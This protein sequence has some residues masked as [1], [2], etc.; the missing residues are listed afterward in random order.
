[1]FDDN[2]VDMVLFDPPYSPHQISV[3]YKQMDRAVSWQDVSASFW[4]KQKD[5]IALKN[6]YM[7]IRI[8]PKKSVIKQLEKIF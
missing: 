6:G 8:R 7:T 4:S 5:E 1:M 3:C 2:S